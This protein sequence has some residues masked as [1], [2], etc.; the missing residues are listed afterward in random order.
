MSGERRL[1]GTDEVR[2]QGR[3]YRRFPDHK[4]WHRR[5]YFMATTAPRTY[6]HRDI[7]EHEHGPLPEG[8]HVHHMDHDPLNNSIS[9]LVAITAAE[10]AAL[11]ALEA[12]RYEA[13]CD[14]C[15][16]TFSAVHKRA[17]WCST[18]CKQRRRRR[19]GTAYVRPKAVPMW[20]RRQCEECG[21]AYFARKPWARFCSSAC[22]QRTG[23]KA[24][25]LLREE[26]S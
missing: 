18:A 26:K 23:R 25:K 17:R 19:E 21:N 5:S 11:H 24:K 7:Y 4:S 16:A 15:G 9:N 13:V 3:R 14:E 8:M 2:W 22:K 6:L 1:P 12:E 20:E 10:H